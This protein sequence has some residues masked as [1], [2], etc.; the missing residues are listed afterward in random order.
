[1]VRGKRLFQANYQSGLRILKLKKP[2]RPQEIGYF[3]TYPEANDP[4]F[5]GAWG[6]F[7]DF[8]SGVVIVSD[9]RRGLFVLIPTKN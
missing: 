7:S 8:P 2:K 5:T 1:M 9:V 6:V 4:T 3:D